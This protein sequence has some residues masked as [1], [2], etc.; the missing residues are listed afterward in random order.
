MTLFGVAAL[1]LAVLA[2]ISAC[3]KIDGPQQGDDGWN[4]INGDRPIRFSANIATPATKTDQ[5]ISP[6]TSNTTFG[7]FATKANGWSNSTTS[8]FMFNE[9][10]HYDGT[11]Y[12]Y[13]PVKYWPNNGDRISFWAYSPYT[14][15]A[16]DAIQ[17]RKLADPN[18]IY[19][20]TTTNIPEIKYTVLSGR[21]DLLVSGP[22]TNKAKQKINEK[23]SFSFHHALS[24][25][26]FK[27]K[28][29]SADP[30]GYN[31]TVTLNGIG[32][33]WIYK[34]GL[35]RS[36]NNTHNSTPWTDL[37]DADNTVFYAY[38][39]ATGMGVTQTSAVDVSGA[40][41]M[42]IPQNLE[43]LGAKLYVEYTVSL[44]GG[45]PQTYQEEASLDISPS[46]VDVWQEGK[47]YTYTIS[48]TP[49]Q[50]IIFTVTCDTWGDVYNWH[51]TN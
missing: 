34:S 14:T 33:K 19:T 38:N 32:F 25:I 44:N 47:Q 41:V 4:D 9:D 15:E 35:H 51:L 36:V 31:Y 39:P 49:G 40:T 10:V 42:L 7:V 6:N 21:T 1:A 26:S 2:G 43:T 8:N 3:A 16:A 50:P 13:A 12:S 23:I 5:P 18:T 17:F 27:V 11:T 48:I 46:E 30:V 24:K 28:K 45:T 29:A 37:D 20:N 22:V